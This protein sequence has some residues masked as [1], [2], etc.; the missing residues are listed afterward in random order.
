MLIL[1]HPLYG[2]VLRADIPPLRLRRL[3]RE[4][5]F[6]ITQTEAPRPYDVLRSVVW[7]LES[8]DVPDLD[9]LLE[10]ARARPLVQLCHRRTPG[11]GRGGG[12]RLDRCRDPFG[13][14]SHHGG[15]SG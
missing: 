10:A 5:A 7:R 11:P 2:E 9:D 15:S 3:R 13:R 8:G 14:D 1:G 6:A 4:L 12:R